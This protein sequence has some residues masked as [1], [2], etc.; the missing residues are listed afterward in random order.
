MTRDFESRVLEC[1]PDESELLL[2]EP[3]QN[4]RGMIELDDGRLLSTNI[5]G[6]STSADGG[7]TWSET[8]PLRH[9]NGDVIS[10]RMLYLQRL[11]SGAIGGFVIPTRETRAKGT[12]QLPT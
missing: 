3:M 1:I 10:G 2:I 11:K 12:V 9:A 4:P 7:K 6:A 8:Q 5:Q